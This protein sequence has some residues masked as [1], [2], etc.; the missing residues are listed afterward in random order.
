MFYVE[1]TEYGIK[2]SVNIA[3]C[4]SIEVNKSQTGQRGRDIFNITLQTPKDPVRINFQTE[5]QLDKAFESLM[6]AIQNNQTR[7]WK[8]PTFDEP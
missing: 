8:V 3:V 7:H 2:K 4:H 6:D 1:Y 5:E